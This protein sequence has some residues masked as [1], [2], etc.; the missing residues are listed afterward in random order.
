MCLLGKTQF[1]C[2]ECRGIG[3]HFVARGKS[4]GF[5]RV[6]AGKWGIFSSYER[7]A[8]FKREFV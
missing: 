8:H 6:A 5:S 2:M 1:L 4:H 7:D 3:P